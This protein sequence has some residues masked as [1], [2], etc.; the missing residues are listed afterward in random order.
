MPRLD[1]T[2]H[3]D[4]WRR[5]K[6][7]QSFRA[8]LRRAF[9]V[10]RA[11]DYVYGLEWGDPEFCPPLRFVLKTFLAPHLGAGRRIVEIG[12]GGG[13]WT[14]YMLDAEVI[15]AVDYHQEILD[16]LK[17]AFPEPNV[18]PV[19]NNGTDFPGIPPGSVDLV[20]SYG[21]FTH[22]DLDLIDAYLANIRPLLKASSSV[23]L[24]YSDHT[25]PMSRQNW[26]FADNDPVRMR[27]LI[28]RHGYEILEED[29]VTLWHSAMIRFALPA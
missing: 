16:E 7:E 19:L 11:R 9:D 25:K 3:L 15:H 5:L 24:N 29:T 12:P 14:R 21:T 18:V 27:Q 28:E 8:R 2:L 10:L 13:R 22:L 4:T 17:R 26:K 20:F 6:A 1:T 23:V